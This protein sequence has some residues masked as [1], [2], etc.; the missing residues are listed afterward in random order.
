MV[1]AFDLGEYQKYGFDLYLAKEKQ[2]K[3]KAIELIINMVNTADSM[4][5]LKSRLYRHRK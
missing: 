5:H 1:E 4:D 2:D 3:E